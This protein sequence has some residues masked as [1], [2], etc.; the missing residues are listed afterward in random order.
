MSFQRVAAIVSILCFLA[1]S[2]S[3]EFYPHRIYKERKKT[4]LDFGW[5]FYRNSP[6]GTPSD[7]NYNDAGWVTVNIP[8]SASYDPPTPDGEAQGHQGI[9]WYRK[10]FTVPS[11]AKHTGKVFLEFE[12]AMQS[13]DVYLNGKLLGTHDNSGFTWFGFDISDKVSRTGENVLAVRLDN[14]FTQAI[15]PGRELTVGYPDYYLFSG[16]YRDVW[17]ICTDQCHIPLYGQRISTPAASASSATVRIKTT[18]A[19]AAAGQVKVRY[20]FVD[21]SRTGAFMADSIT[22]SVAENQTVVLDSVFGPIAS[23]ALWS[24]ETPNLYTL[25]TQVYLNDQLADDYVDR[26]GVRWFTWTP[27]EAF[28]LNGQETIIK[29]A[30][31]HQSLGWIQNALPTSRFFKEIALM[32]DMGANLARCAHFPR[33]PSFYNACDELGMLVMVEVPTWGNE[34]PAYPDSFWIRLNNCMKEMIDVGYN[35]PSIISWGTFNEPYSSFNAPTQLPLLNNTAHQLDSTRLT[36]LALNVLNNTSLATAT[37]ICG[38]NYNELVGD[39]ASIKTRI[40]NTEYHEGWIYWCFRGDVND[41]ESASGYAM[42]RWTKWTALFS[43][44]RVNKIAGGCMWSFN[45]YWSPFIQKPMGVVDHYRI[46]KAVYYL[47]RKNW[48]GKAS[49]TPVQGLTPTSLLLTTDNDMLV[50]DSTDIAIITAS[51][52][53]AAGVCVDTKAG[54]SDS[55]PVT[56]TLQGPANN[57]GPLTVKACGGKCALMIKSKNTPGNIVVSATAPNLPAAQPITIPSIPLD[58]SALDIPV[59]WMGKPV[60]QPAYVT[61]KQIKNK[62][63][64]SLPPARK[65]GS[66]VTL[67]SMNGQKMSCPVSVKG[68][69]L[70]I[71]TSALATG[72]YFLSIGKD[73][74]SIKTIF[75]VN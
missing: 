49:E 26:F 38:L 15:P 8:H 74:R 17:L 60:A 48:T 46:P 21:P 50:A 62:L 24:P 37:D 20:T 57:F 2:V 42:Q 71:N 25:Y 10:R 40:I 73:N 56:F 32:K 30:S 67:F 31:V 3:A 64:I 16:L 6:A 27:E 34:C 44:T 53:D 70:T 7:S 43:T 36:Y 13:A 66:T 33:D 18:V 52:R 72:N 59:R 55:I 28:A 61:V 65:S 23:P 4:N 1:L 29:G 12:G 47:F 45:D 19:S 9:C 22:R 14:R 41:N 75:I 11:T 69:M 51:F 54:P 63:L 58:T 35:H 68:G 39:A 5:K